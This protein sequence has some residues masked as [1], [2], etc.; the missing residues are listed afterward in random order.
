M[1]PNTAPTIQDIDN[2]AE[3]VKR[4]RALLLAHRHL[5]MRGP[6]WPADE[7][8]CAARLAEAEERLT[9]LVEGRI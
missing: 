5:P 1:M 2:A 9:R 8:E 4:F 3:V 7:E 6:E